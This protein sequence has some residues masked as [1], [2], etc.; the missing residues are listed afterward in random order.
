MSTLNVGEKRKRESTTTFLKEGFA[1]IKVFNEE[2]IES[3]D[4][5]FKTTLENAPELSNS[6]NHSMPVALGNV[7]YLPLPSFFFGELSQRIHLEAKKALDDSRLID[8]LQPEVKFDDNTP[9]YLSASPDR[10]VYRTTTKTKMDLNA[11]KKSWHQDAA[12]NALPSDVIFGG[13]VNCNTYPQYFRV[14]PGTHRPE[15]EL[16]TTLGIRKQHNNRGFDKFSP[17]DLIKLTNYWTSNEDK[18]SDIEIPPGHMI[19]FFENLVHAVIPNRHQSLGPMQRMHTSWIL[20]TSPVA[21]HDR[22]LTKKAKEAHKPLETYFQEQGLVPVR[23]GQSTPLYS[24][25][26]LFGNNKHLVKGLSKSYNAD[27]VTK[28]KLPMFLSSLEEMQLRKMPLSAEFKDMF[29]PTQIF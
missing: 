3:I 9:W 27:L 14:F 7:Q 28:G 22:P 25:M 29:F 21:L 1:V 19:I 13:W 11:W 18:F 16:F 26:H 6:Y 23:S 4:S 20:S 12:P 15:S 17:N 10:A 24:P 2:Q 8:E 5:E